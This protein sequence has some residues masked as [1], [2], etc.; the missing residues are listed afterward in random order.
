MFQFFQRPQVDSIS[1][2]EAMIGQEAGEVVVIDVREFM[3]LKMSGKA[4]GAKH[5]P[6]SRLQAECDPKS[7][8]YD[9]S[10]TGKTLALYCASGARSGAVAPMLKQ[11]G[12]EDVRN[13]GG[14]MHWQQGGGAVERV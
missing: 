11:M 6:T 7:P 13:I 3:E 5:I 8:E 12:H 9:E 14:L 2:R 10:L 4:K 1:P